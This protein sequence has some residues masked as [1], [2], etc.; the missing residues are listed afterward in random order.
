MNMPRPGERGRT[1]ELVAR[2][3]REVKA[4]PSR[5][6]PFGMAVAGG[7][8]LAAAGAFAV[9]WGVIGARADLA[10]AWLMPAFLFKIISMALLAGGA[11]LLLRRSGIPGMANRDFLV[12]A[13]AALVLAAG[14]LFDRSGFPFFGRND[15]SIVRC[16]AFIV[17]AA[18]PGLAVL[19]FILRKGVPTDLVGA[20]AVAGLAAGSLGALAYALACINDGFA[21]V[22]IWYPAAIATTTLLGAALGPRVLAW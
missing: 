17:F 22:A 14:A 15:L 11:L 10:E 3:A 12:L 21:F 1:D 18:L 5:R 9:V 4:P 16:M 6:L 2:L 7:A 13:P 19:L 20:G 8:A